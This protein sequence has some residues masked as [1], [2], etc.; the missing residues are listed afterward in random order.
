[1]IAAYFLILAAAPSAYSD[2]EAQMNAFSVLED[3]GKRDGLPLLEN[4]RTKAGFLRALERHC[5]VPV[6]SMVINAAG[7]VQI[8]DST[9]WE[10]AVGL[11]R[12]ACVMA[13]I[14]AQRQ[15]I[16]RLGVKIGP[17]GSEFESK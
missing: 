3:L 7:A 1:M 15:A 12:Q 10:G 8:L 4:F 17:R 13:G 11:D 5:A 6:P 16:A 9:V 2:A 14:F